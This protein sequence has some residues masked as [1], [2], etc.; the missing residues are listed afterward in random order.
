MKRLTALREDPIRENS[1]GCEVL[2]ENDETVGE[3]WV[4][5][6]L[7]TP[8]YRRPIPLAY[9]RVTIATKPQ[10][11]AKYRLAAS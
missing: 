9:R 2:L 10:A 4:H 6:R 7:L 11:A 8:F 1:E 3:F 5:Q